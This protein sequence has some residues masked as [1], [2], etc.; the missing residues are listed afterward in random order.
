MAVV[1]LGPATA[2]GLSRALGLSVSPLPNH[3]KIMLRNYTLDATGGLPPGVTAPAFPGNAS[4]LYL[5]VLRSI[6]K[7]EWLDTLKAVGAR[8]VSY[9]PENSYLVQAP[10]NAL[11]ALRA[12]QGPVIN[13]L[14]YVPAF[15]HLEDKSA[16]APDGFG[17][18]MVKVLRVPTN[19]ATVAEIRDAALPGTFSSFE[20]AEATCLL[21]VLSATTV[22]GLA[23]EPDVI[24][25][26][27][28]PDIHPSGERSALIVAGQ[29]DQITEGNRDVF[30]PKCSGDYHDYYDWLSAK[31]L[32]D[33]SNIKLGLMDTGLDLGSTSDVHADFLN[34][35]TPPASRVAYQ[36]NFGVSSGAQDCVGHGTLVAA[37]MAGSGGSTNA[38]QFSES[39][40]CP[41]NSF[42]MGTGIAPRAR[43]ASAKIWSDNDYDPNPPIPSRVAQALEYFGAWEA[44]VANLSSNTIYHNYSSYCELLD[45]CVRDT[46]PSNPGGLSGPMTIT[47]AAGNTD[48]SAAVFEPAVAKNVIAVGASESYNKNLY[49]DHNNNEACGTAAIAD[50]AYDIATFSAHGTVDG[51]IKPDVVAPGTRSMGAGSRDPGY[52]GGPCMGRYLCEPSFVATD[53]TYGEAWANGTSFAAPVAAGAAGL[54]GQWY[55]S[56]HN[57]VAPSPAMKKAMIINSALDIHG[58]WYQPDGNTTISVDHIPSEYQGWGKV[59]LRRSFPAAGSWYA[60]DQSVLFTTS[61]GTAWTG[62]FAANIQD[63]PVRVTLVWTDAPGDPGTGH[64]LKNDLDLKVW[65][66]DSNLQCVM[67][68]GNT[69]ISE[70]SGLSELIPCTSTLTLDVDNNVEQVIFM[71]TS[72]IAIFHVIVTPRVIGDKAVPL[73]T[74]TANQDFALFIENGHQI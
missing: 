24:S 3:D 60:L 32:S 17:G 36:W 26:E 52:A 51:R 57:N 34:T 46:D 4:N 1:D 13:V 25:I 72:S 58:G 35:A 42:S 63:R 29:L 67:A 66:V 14:P 48:V 22:D 40:S 62:N 19:N 5:V 64:L 70:S 21:G 69:S 50:N 33:T 73:G 38:T 10:L 56:T 12:K 9:V 16:L 31:G 43:I 74:G 68:G 15:R 41:G 53:G 2:P 28:A 61:G 30:V 8:L 23:Y 6:P 37:M 20:L 59:D 47:V 55:R 71:P 54:L 27:R 18:V 65:T 45:A 39:V 7:P 11:E 44:D 49:L